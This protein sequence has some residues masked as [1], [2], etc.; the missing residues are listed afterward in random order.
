M[1]K[2]I[3]KALKA[4]PLFEGLTEQ[5][6]EKDMSEV[7]YSL[8]K[9]NKNDIYA[10]TGDFYSHADIV[11]NGELSVKM[12][13]S[14]GRCV[15][16]GSYMMGKLSTPAQLFYDK[17]P[18]Q[19]TIEAVRPTTL[20]SMSP[21]SLQ[22]LF[23]ID[24]RIQMNFIKL[25]SSVAITLARMVRQLTLFT[26]REKV[27]HYLD[28]LSKKRNSNVITLDVSRQEIADRFAIQKYSLQ[29]VLGEFDKGGAIKLR[30]K[31]ITILDREKLFS[32][33]NP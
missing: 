15:K 33:A 29:R 28:E 10:S 14:S 8:Y 12:E 27:A 17:M 3:M 23:S 30:G 16:I 1:E 9:Y 6:I 18:L 31:Y 25:L 4:C 13:R 7:D 22:K 26:V 11:I 5:E 21:S 32:L 2:S 24:Q 20:L 19:V